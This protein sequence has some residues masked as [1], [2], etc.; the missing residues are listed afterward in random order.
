MSDE[1][2]E[3]RL[4]EVNGGTGEKYFLYTVERGD[5]LSRLAGRF[6]TT[7]QNIIDL[8]PMIWN[9]KELRPGWILRIPEKVV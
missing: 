1:L 4:E 3:S 2:S 5:N 9:Q 6:G 8:N 7:V